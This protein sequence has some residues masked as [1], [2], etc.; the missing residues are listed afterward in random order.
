MALQGAAFGDF[1]RH[2]LA[3]DGV[4]VFN[5]DGRVVKRDG[6]DLL[7]LLFRLVQPLGYQGVGLFIEHDGFL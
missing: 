4:G 7:P 2:P 1:H 6:A 5:G 3:L